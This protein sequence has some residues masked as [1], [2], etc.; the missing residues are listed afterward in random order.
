MPHSF[1][2]IATFT[3]VIARTLATYQIDTKPMFSE[4]GLAAEPYLDPDSRIPISSMHEIWEKAELLSGNPCIAFD[5][6]MSFHATNFHAV[7]YAMLASST[8]REALERIVRYQRLLSTSADLDMASSEHFVEFLIR[9][10]HV[11]QLAVMSNRLA[12]DRYGPTG[13]G[14]G[15]LYRHQLVFP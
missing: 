1:T 15:R 4:V 2:S 13:K 3:E 7:G 8:L 9:G 10:T 12:I 11:P 6:G 5:V 14:I